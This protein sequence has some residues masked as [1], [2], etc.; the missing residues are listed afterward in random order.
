MLLVIVGCLVFG[1]QTGISI[2]LGGL[3][4][5]VNFRWM[6]SGVDRIL[7]GKGEAETGWTAVK[8][9]GRLVLMLLGL[10][11]MIQASFLSAGGVLAGLSIFVLSGMLEALLILFESKS[12]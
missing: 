7:F 6:E 8:F 2:A 9:L 5:W 1:W 3:L 10:F 11:A 12:G 4:A